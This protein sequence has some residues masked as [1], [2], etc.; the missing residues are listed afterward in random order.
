MKNKKVIFIST[1]C[2][3]VF[4]ACLYLF[5]MNFVTHRNPFNGLKYVPSNMV[6][7]P[8]S[9][10]ENWKISKS[11]ATSKLKKA[12]FDVQYIY[13]GPVND[14]NLVDK[15]TVDPIV[16]NKNV[17]QHFQKKKYSFNNPEDKINYGYDVSDSG[18]N[19]ASKG[20]TVVVRVKTNDL[21]KVIS[22]LDTDN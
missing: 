11:T 13:D 12:G 21:D 20:A 4:V 15:A 22:T 1:T 3:I 14:D 18:D 17:I 8:I 19:Y 5:T 2:T 16:D 6:K 7:I 9:S 10:S